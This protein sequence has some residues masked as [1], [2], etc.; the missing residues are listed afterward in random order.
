M[1]IT[2]KGFRSALIMG[3][4]CLL[5]PALS[6]GAETLSEALKEIS[7]SG[8][9]N[10]RY[11]DVDNSTITSD[12]LSLRSRITLTTG[13]IGRFS[14]VAGFEDVRNILG[15]DDSSPSQNAIGVTLIND[16]EV[17]EIDQAYIQY[18]TDS[19]TAKLGRQVL[20]LDNNR[21]IGAAPW[22]QDRRTMDALRI[23]FKPMSNIVIDASYVYIY[24]QGPAEVNDR[25]AN[26]FLLNGS[27]NTNLG[28]L[29]AYAYLLDDETQNTEADQYGVRFSGSTDTNNTTFLYTAEYA[30]QSS[31]SFDAEYLLLEAG[32]T[33][34]GITAK[35]GY[36]LRGSDNGEYVFQTPLSRG[37]GVNGWADIYNNLNNTIFDGGL[38][39][40]E[41][42]FIS[43]TGKI[44]TVSLDAVYHQFDADFGSVDLG[45]ELDLRATMPLS[46]SLNAGFKYADFSAGDSRVPLDTD[47]L[48]FWLTYSF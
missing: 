26:T 1:S 14:A 47:K 33:V 17:T 27:Y 3:T 28:K 18:K 48:W 25:D 45:S 36:E 12:R 41:D 44:G 30:T 5:L 35:F 29:V 6:H 43:I 13:S 4:S 23:Q 9:F 10:L 40:F 11:E 31:E 22:R 8:N 16:A 15:I 19:V 7:V 37:H 20:E 38:T 2:K 34:S 32:V 24:N 39:G 46:E 21:M 42:S